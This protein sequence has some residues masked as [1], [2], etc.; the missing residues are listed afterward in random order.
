MWWK[1]IQLPLETELWSNE[2]FH[3]KK[4]KNEDFDTHHLAQS[5]EA[6]LAEMTWNDSVLF[7]FC[8]G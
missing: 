4:H 6:W 2:S 5:S 3:L 7:S 1:R 8:N